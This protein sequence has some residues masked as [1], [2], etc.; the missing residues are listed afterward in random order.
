MLLYLHK[1]PGNLEVFLKRVDLFA[2]HYWIKEVLF[3]I[4]LDVGPCL[5]QVYQEE[6]GSF[7]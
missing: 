6:E 3:L 4:I 5:G 7:S 1:T 2:L